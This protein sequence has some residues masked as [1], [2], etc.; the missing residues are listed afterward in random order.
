MDPVKYSAA[1]T[2]TRHLLMAA[3]LFNNQIIT[4]IFVAASLPI[5]HYVTTRHF[6]NKVSYIRYPVSGIIF[7]IW[8][9]FFG[10]CHL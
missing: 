8:N 4:T 3:Y 1:Y 5:I 2:A 6:F 9:L 7:T 10:I